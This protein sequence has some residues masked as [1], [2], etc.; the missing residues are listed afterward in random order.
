MALAAVVGWLLLENYRA[1]A[2]RRSDLLREHAAALV[3]RAAVLGNVLDIAERSLRRGRR[4]ARGGR[5]AGVARTGDER[6]VRPGALPGGDPG[7][8]AHGHPPRASSAPEPAFSHVALL[9][10]DGNE[11]A[12][13]GPAGDVSGITWRPPPEEADGIL[14]AP[15]GTRLASPAPGGPGRKAR[16]RPRGLAHARP[17]HARP[18]PGVQEERPR[19]RTSYLVDAAGAPFRG[20]RASAT[21]RPCRRTPTPSPPT[22][23]PSPSRT[24]AA[25]GALAPGGPRVGPGK[26][27]LPRRRPPVRRVL[28]ERPVRG[29]VREPGGRG[30]AGPGRGG[31]GGGDE[32]ARPRPPHP[33]GGVE[34]AGAGG[35]GEDRGPGAGGRRAAAGRAVPRGARQRARA[36]RRRGGHRRH[37][38]A[39]RPRQRGLRA[40]HRPARRRRPWPDAAR[41]VRPGRGGHA[42]GAGP[43][44]RP[45]GRGAT[46]AGCSAGARAD[47][48]PSTRGS[49]WR[50]C[51]TRPAP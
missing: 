32:R 47:G 10:R 20:A 2:R 22:G 23:W 25:G 28:P 30:G 38:A 39:H 18:R 27:P 15:D 31:P 43:A 36:E 24:R 37:G 21:R 6:A 40:D 42:R 11:V 19:P 35:G 41:G 16:R 13:V 1:T 4:L 34:R 33:A 5:A 7:P 50:R 51:G 45:S 44:R 3:L 29:L 49:R 9:D 48:R 12:G 14:L 46:G 17:G 26:A 8:A